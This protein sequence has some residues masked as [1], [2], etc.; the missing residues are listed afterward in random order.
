MRG[1]R[2][3]GPFGEGGDGPVTLAKGSGLSDFFASCEV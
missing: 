1:K 3:C 2:V